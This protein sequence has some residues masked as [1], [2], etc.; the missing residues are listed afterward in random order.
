MDVSYDGYNDV[1][2]PS[3]NVWD[4]IQ[5]WFYVNGIKLRASA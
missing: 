2:I 3:G 4:I 1:I 5:N